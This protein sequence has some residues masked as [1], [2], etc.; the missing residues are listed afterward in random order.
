MIC[1]MN[2]FVVKTNSWYST[3]RGKSS[4]KE[5]FGWMVTDCNEN[6]S[7]Y[8]SFQFSVNTLHHL[9]V[10]NGFVRPPFWQTSDMVKVPRS[11]RFPY[12]FRFR[13]VWNH[14]YFNALHQ[15]DELFSDISRS[16]HRSKERITAEWKTYVYSYLPVLYVV[17]VTPLRRIICVPP[18]IIHIQ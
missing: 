7:F 17:L 14:F 10:F 11:N 9:I 18:L 3:H 4:N 2:S 5:L 13:N 12:V 6:V 16:S 8:D 15:P 1:L